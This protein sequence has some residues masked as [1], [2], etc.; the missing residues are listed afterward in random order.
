[1]RRPGKLVFRL[2]DRAVAKETLRRYRS[3]LKDFADWA[4]NNNLEASS[5]DELDRALCEYVTQL[6]D[7]DLQS[8]T[9][10]GGICPSACEKGC[11]ILH[12]MSRS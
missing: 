10:S 7:A 9:V 6:F 2:V 5:Y 1:M 11:G 12:P 3:A 4:R 8:L